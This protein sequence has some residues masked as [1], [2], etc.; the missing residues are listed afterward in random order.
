MFSALMKVVRW[1]GNKKR[2]SSW[3]CILFLILT[4]VSAAHPSPLPPVMCGFLRLIKWREKPDL[5]I[6]LYGWAGHYYLIARAAIYV[7]ESTSRG[8]RSRRTFYEVRIR[9]G[10][11][12]ERVPF[13]YFDNHPSGE[14][15]L[16]THKSSFHS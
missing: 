2:E 16:G 11:A 12:L 1:T 6:A 15:P 9:I 13:G 10:E 8:N 14:I 3:L 5:K 4:L 7:V